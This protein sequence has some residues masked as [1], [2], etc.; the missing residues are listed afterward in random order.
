M[1]ELDEAEIEPF[2]FDGLIVPM[3]RLTLTDEPPD[4]EL[5]VGAQ[6]YKYARSYPIKGY[7]AV[8]PAFIKE[9]LS[10]GQKPLLIERP[11]RLYVY[12]GS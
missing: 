4:I 9:Q 12:L 1:L 3:I 7:S 5:K 11:D 10:S 8:L 6:T 2:P